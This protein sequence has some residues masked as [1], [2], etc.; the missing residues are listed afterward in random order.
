MKKGKVFQNFVAVLIG[1]F[2]LTGCSDNQKEET[3]S[4]STIFKDY[5]IE[6]SE[7]GKDIAYAKYKDQFTMEAVDLPVKTNYC[8][9]YDSKLYY[10][11]VP[12]DFETGENVNRHCT[13]YSCELDGQNPKRI[14]EISDG[15]YIDIFIQEG[16]LYCS[17]VTS[18]RDINRYIVDLSSETVTQMNKDKEYT[19]VRALTKEGYYYHDYNE[20]KIYYCDY[21]KENITLFCEPD[22]NIQ[23][24]YRNNNNLY[25]LLRNDKDRSLAIYDDTGKYIESYSISD[26]LGNLQ[27][28]FINIIRAE[29]DILYLEV[30]TGWDDSFNNTYLIRM[31]LKDGTKQ[32]CGSWYTP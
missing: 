16:I 24:L 12:I 32:V 18:A 17:A 26:L 13:I 25:V 23:S 11:D 5:T 30:I 9:I 19:K 14:L 2:L 8:A 6:I 27:G 29:G 21:D 15:D 28:Q 10:T 22:G 20:D 7:N 1:I 4:G 3:Q 31:N